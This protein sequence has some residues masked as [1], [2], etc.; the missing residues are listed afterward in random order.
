M[1]GSFVVHSIQV[2]SFKQ[3][4]TNGPAGIFSFSRERI[5]LPQVQPKRELKMWRS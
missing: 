2:S 3:G 4:M 1:T 5:L